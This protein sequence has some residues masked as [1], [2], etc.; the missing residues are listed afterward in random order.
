MMQLKRQPKRK[1]SKVQRKDPMSISSFYNNQ[2]VGYLI[3]R[4]ESEKNLHLWETRDQR[5]FQDEIQDRIKWH[6]LVFSW[7][8]NRLSSANSSECLAVLM[9]ELS[10]LRPVKIASLASVFAVRSKM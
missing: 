4:I 8:L 2:I 9:C 7:R 3:L 1:A 10:S 6:P 5:I